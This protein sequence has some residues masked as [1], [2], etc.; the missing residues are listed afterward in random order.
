MPRPFW[1]FG[2]VMTL[3]FDVLT[4]FKQFTLY[5]QFCTTIVNL[6]KLPQ[7]RLKKI[8]FTNVQYTCMHRRT[9]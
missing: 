5:S 8:K 6:I 4:Q 2:L 3:T 1:I 7:S 9:T